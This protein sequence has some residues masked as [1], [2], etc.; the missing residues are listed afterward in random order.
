MATQTKTRTARGTASKTGAPGANGD[1]AVIAAADLQPLLDALRSG[2]RGE[3]GV[4]LDARKR[5]LVGQLNK[6]FN[7]S[8]RR[9]ASAPR[10][11]SSGLRPQSAAK[12]ASPTAPN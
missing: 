11:R 2:V 10:T 1:A 5:G 6:A 12:A 8:S 7:E 3:T 9:H 4:R